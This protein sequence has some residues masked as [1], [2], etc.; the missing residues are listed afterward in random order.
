MWRRGLI[1]CLVVSPSLLSQSPL[2]NLD[3]LSAV[4]PRTIT[5]KDAW[6]CGTDWSFGKDPVHLCTR[7]E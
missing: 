5:S 3:F 2:A 7:S 4:G 6:V 1:L